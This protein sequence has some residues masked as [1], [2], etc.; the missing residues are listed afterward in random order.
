MHRGRFVNPNPG[1]DDLSPAAVAR[2]IIEGLWVVR[3]PAR[4]N[5]RRAIKLTQTPAGHYQPQPVTLWV[6]AHTHLPLRMVNGAGTLATQVDWSYLR[7]I[8]ANLALL[9]VPIP[10]GYPRVTPPGSG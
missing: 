1:L 8:A 3:G 2:D 9:R 5:G 7:P 10:H 4:L 6:D